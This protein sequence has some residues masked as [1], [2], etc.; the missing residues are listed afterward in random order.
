M[1]LYLC[2][3]DRKLPDAAGE[4]DLFSLRILVGNGEVR[5]GDRRLLQIN[6]DRVRS[7]LIMA[8]HLDLDLRAMRTVPFQPLLSVDVRLVL[9][10]I[11]RDI[12]FRG[13][14]FTLDAADDVQRLADGELPVH[15][16]G[17]DPHALLAA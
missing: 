1:R 8:L 16:R 7:L 6:L 14:L 2:R 15:A 9:G 4:A 11:N 5:I 3:S 10:G 12:H 17:R 13:K